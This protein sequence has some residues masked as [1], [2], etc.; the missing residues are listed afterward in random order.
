MQPYLSQ[1]H[2]GLQCRHLGT[3][4]AGTTLFMRGPPYLDSYDSDILLTKGSPIM[5]TV[6][7]TVST[8]STKVT[9]LNDTATEL[10]RSLL[11]NQAMIRR[12]DAVARTS[13][14]EQWEE[15]RKV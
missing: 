7:R 1:H 6:F 15:R 3:D 5:A 8:F 2:P 13:F 12:I 9:A 14:L 11:G 10:R 4:G